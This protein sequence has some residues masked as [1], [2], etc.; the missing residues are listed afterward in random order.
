MEPPAD[1][2]ALREAP[3]DLSDQ[4]M[5][6][7]LDEAASLSEEIAAESEDLSGD[8]SLESDAEQKTIQGQPSRSQPAEA[9]SADEPPATSPATD[10]RNDLPDLLHDPDAEATTPPPQPDASTTPE[11]PPRKADP[12]REG[13][14]RSE[15]HHEAD[16]SESEDSKAPPSDAPDQTQPPAAKRPLRKRLAAGVGSALRSALQIPVATLNAW[17]RMV[18]LLDR[19]FCGWSLGVKRALGIAAVAT[20]LMGIGAWVLPGLLNHNPFADMGRFT[21]TMH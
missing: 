3:L 9:I 20:L 7:L 18:I 17:L 4:E 5:E 15:E 14:S 21:Q 2:V 19:P 6:R 8:P 13:K 1:N 12:R 11:L 16:N 10:R